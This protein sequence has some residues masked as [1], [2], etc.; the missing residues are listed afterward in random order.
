[1]GDSSRGA[2]S[3]MIPCDVCGKDVPASNMT[4]HKLRA[5]QGSRKPA[6]RTDDETR[7]NNSSSPSNDDVIPMEIDEDS[8]DGENVTSTIIETKVP[9]RRTGPDLPIHA[10]ERQRYQTAGCF[11]VQHPQSGRLLLV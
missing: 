8:D 1:M 4:M 5:C 9:A 3:E 2:A 7:D 11:P 6:A 10:Q